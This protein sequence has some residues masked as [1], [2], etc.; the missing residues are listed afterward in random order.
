MNSSGEDARI[1][2][3]PA[4]IDAVHV[5]NLLVGCDPA[6]PLS[7]SV[8]YIRKDEYC[9]PVTGSGVNRNRPYF[10]LAQNILPPL[11]MTASIIQS[12]QR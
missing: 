2:S 3:D 12:A 11:A 1:L 5:K 6:D 7:D 10:S 9:R 8:K 4:D